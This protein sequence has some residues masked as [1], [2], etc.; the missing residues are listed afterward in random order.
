MRN[1]HR[2]IAYFLYN[3]IFLFSR[4]TAIVGKFVKSLNCFSLQRRVTIIILTTRQSYI[5]LRITHVMI[6][7]KKKVHYVNVMRNNKFFIN[8]EQ[9]K[10]TAVGSKST[11][12]SPVGTKIESNVMY[13]TFIVSL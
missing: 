8:T 10:K 11:Y 9:E 6:E 2:N 3:Y 5:F 1:F 13:N 12:Q 7:I 4:N